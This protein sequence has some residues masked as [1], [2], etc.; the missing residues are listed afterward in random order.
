MRQLCHV[1]HV[2]PAAYYAW[3]RH[4]RQHLASSGARVL[5]LPQPALWHAAT[6]G[7]S[8]G[9]RPYGGPL[10]HPPRA[11]RPRPACPTAALVRAAHHRFGPDRAR[12]AQPLVG[13]TGPYRTQPSLGGRHHLPAPSGRRLA[14][15]GRVARPLLAQNCGLGRARHHARGPGQRGATPSLGRTPAWVVVHSDQGSQYTATRFKDILAR[16]GAVQSMSR[17]GNCYDNAHAE[18]F[19]SRFKA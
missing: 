19:W 6:A 7:R 8:A 2:A 16:N 9:P 5:C 11:P 18:S 17:R 12:R 14:V 10:A 3:Q 4:R 13:P 15:P 1:L